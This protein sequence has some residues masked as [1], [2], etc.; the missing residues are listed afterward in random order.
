MSHSLNVRLK[1]NSMS[2]WVWTQEVPSL[3]RWDVVYTVC[4]AQTE[5]AC[6]GPV[7]LPHY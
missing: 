2:K 1:P 5:H 7:C 3:S 6:G 4:F